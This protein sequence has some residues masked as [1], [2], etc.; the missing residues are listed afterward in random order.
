MESTKKMR[1]DVHEKPPFGEG[2]L[3]SFQ[4]VFAMFGATIL[5]PMILGLDVSTILFASGL[6][7]IIFLVLTKFEMPVY[8]GSSFAYI[9]AIAY[10][11]NEQG[12]EVGAAQ[13]GIMLVGTLYM[14]V[15]Y[16]IKKIGTAWINRLFPPV[17]IGSMVIVIGL[18]LAST[19]V[20]NAGLVEGAN[21]REPLVAL[22]TFAVSAYI[23]SRAKG[24]ISVIPFLVAMLVGYVASLLLGLVDFSPVQEAAWLNLPQLSLPFSTGGLFKEYQITFSPA[25]FAMLPVALV[26]LAEHLGDVIVLSEMTGHD[27]AKKPG[28]HRT[29]LGD[30]VASFISAFMGGVDVTTYG[31]NTGVVGL[32]RVASTSVIKNAAIIAIILSFCGKFT[33]LISTIPNA[34]LGGMS[35]LL[36]GVIASNG[37]KVLVGNRVDYSQSRNLIITSA[38]LV[39]GLGGAVLEIGNFVTLSGT[40]LSALVGIILNLVLPAETNPA[41]QEI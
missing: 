2:L 17:V 14:I 6:G 33:A 8:L 21:W 7:T 26:T 30:G 3:L 19:A 41:G 37:L 34:V 40:A 31:E 39:I 4:H 25:A 5:V 27:F 28:L 10:A 29:I 22:I 11:I 35:I 16:I 36:Y 12:G 23:Q 38:M 20:Q 1:Y 18:G 15:A 24:F 32:T 9:S 13:T